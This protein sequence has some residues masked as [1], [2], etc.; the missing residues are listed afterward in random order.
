MLP[1]L[2][3]LHCNGILILNTITVIVPLQKFRQNFAK[4]L[5]RTITVT[6]PLVLPDYRPKVTIT[7]KLKNPKFSQTKV[8]VFTRNRT[9]KQ[10]WQK[11]HNSVLIAK[12]IQ[13]FVSV[14]NIN[15]ES[16]I[17]WC[18]GLMKNIFQELFQTWNI[19]QYCFMITPCTHLIIFPFTQPKR[20][21]KLLMT[22][23]QNEN[24]NKQN[25]SFLTNKTTK[26]K[27]QQNNFSNYFT[28]SPTEI[29]RTPRSLL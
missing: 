21:R 17:Y 12:K 15:N 4:E 1:K 8:A 7:E 20:E 16:Q 26:E 9:N 28:F 23:K 27:L 10:L 14:T 29:N 19:Q 25:L 18:N 13:H 3:T 11:S 24:L 6:V 2:Q 5:L 22:A